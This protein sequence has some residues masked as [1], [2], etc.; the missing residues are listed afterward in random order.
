MTTCA[1]DDCTEKGDGVLIHAGAYLADI[2]EVHAL[3]LGVDE[4][5]GTPGPLGGVTGHY[6][7]NPARATGW[8][9][10]L[11]LGAPAPTITWCGDEADPS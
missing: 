11:D 6:V 10:T 4:V 8:V 7:L 3:A 9:F 5:P 2:C 1:I